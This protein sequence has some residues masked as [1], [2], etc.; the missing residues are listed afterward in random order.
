MRTG[1]L[2]A[3]VGLATSLSTSVAGAQSAQRFSVQVSGLYASLFGKT[4][5]GLKDGFGGEAQLRFTPGALSF[6][7]GFQYT[8]HDD[9]IVGDKVKLYGG[10]FEPRYVIS[11]GSEHVAPYISTRFSVLR[12]SFNV[13][14]F[15]G[16]ATGVT[17]NGGGGLLVR[18][19]SRVNLDAGATYGYTKFGDTEVVNHATGETTRVPS[20]S[21]SN[22]I[23]RIGLAI[24]IGG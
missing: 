17:L 12:E 14:D 9:Q 7:A 3:A 13:G 5:E 4:Y 21:G 8:S 11:A 23:G 22:I 15:S 16:A 19:T 1:M 24:G 2:M 10:F 20:G 18:L 6:G